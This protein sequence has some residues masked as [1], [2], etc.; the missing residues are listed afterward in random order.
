MIEFFLSLLFFKREKLFRMNFNFVFFF[1]NE[2]EDDGFL[3]SD[4]GIGMRMKVMEYWKCF[5]IGFILGNS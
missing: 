4:I 5:E 1:S 3:I 2:D